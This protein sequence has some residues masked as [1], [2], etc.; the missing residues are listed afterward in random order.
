MGVQVDFGGGRGRDGVSPPWTV[1]GR[2]NTVP[3]AK[4]ERCARVCRRLWGRW[5][6]GG[7]NHPGAP[8]C[9]G[10]YDGAPLCLFDVLAQVLEPFARFS[11]ILKRS[12]SKSD[13]RCS[14]SLEGRKETA[15][16]RG[17]IRRCASAPR[18]AGA[19]AERSFING[20]AIVGALRRQSRRAGVR[21]ANGAP[22]T[23]GPRRLSPT[24]ARR[25]RG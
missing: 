8:G 25:R 5:T 18:P 1:Q 2:G 7:A 24:V 13:F 11:V 15:R 9:A 6:A 23:D 22:W 14:I 10:G 16:G 4:I 19:L 12:V 20:C 3:T 21:G 17:N